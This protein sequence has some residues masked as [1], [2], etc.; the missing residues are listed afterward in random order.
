MFKLP[1]ITGLYRPHHVNPSKDGGSH[2]LLM[3]ADIDYV[4]GYSHL[5]TSLLYDLLAYRL[6]K[7]H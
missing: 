7:S 3:L 2:R 4:G 5:H 6:P 1:V